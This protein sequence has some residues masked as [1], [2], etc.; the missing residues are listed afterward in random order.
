MAKKKP[1]K[2]H[3]KYQWLS[4]WYLLVLAAIFG[5]I[6]VIAM[7]Q[8]NLNMVKLRDGVFAADKKDGDIEGALR[9]LRQYIYSHMNT[10]LNTDTSVYPPI[11]LKYEY[12]RLVEAEAKRAGAASD[13]IYIQAQKICETR[14]PDSF[15]GG[16]R[17]PCIRDYVTK[18]TV[19]EQSIPDALYKF[20]F[21]SPAWSPDLAGW[22]LVLSIIFLAL[23]GLRL[24]LDLW[25][26]HDIGRH[27]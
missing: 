13:Q 19:K 3:R 15:S 21:V 18:N 12:E 25:V 27:L 24:G 2:A 22:A 10:N 26:K 1:H 4:P 6:S 7:R 16:P 23:F 5:V 8:N 14:Y 11:Q 9:N 17:V 20:D